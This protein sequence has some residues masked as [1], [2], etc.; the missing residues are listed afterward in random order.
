MS[1]LAWF[2]SADIV[3]EARF[4]CSAVA[5]WQLEDSDDWNMHV[6][7]K[8]IVEILEQDED[9]PD[10]WVEETMRWSCRSL[11]VRRGALRWR[12]D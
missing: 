12:S 3:G 2:P 11:N 8:N 7:Y 10:E 4:A 5:E 9:D 1:L 6:F